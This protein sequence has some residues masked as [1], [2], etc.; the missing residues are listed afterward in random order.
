MNFN[1]IEQH[2]RLTLFSVSMIV[3]TF[4]TTFSLGELKPSAS[5]DYADLLGE[6]GIVAVTL[7]WIVVILISRPAG[8]LTNF[9][10][11]GL[12]FMHVS[13]LADFLDE[14]LYYSQEQVWITAYE[15]IPAPI[16][17]LLT[18]YGLFQWHKEQVS[19][20]QQLRKREQSLRHHQTI[21]FITGL[22]NPQFMTAQI[23]RIIERNNLKNCHLMMLDI[24]HFDQF[25]RKH[26]DPAADL[27]LRELSELFLMNIRHTDLLCRYAGDRFIVLMTN[28]NH[29]GVMALTKQLESAIA[30]YAIKPT[31]SV[32]P[33][34]LSFTFS[35][36]S[37]YEFECPQ[38]AFDLLNQRMEQQKQL[39]HQAA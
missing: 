23:D 16:G 32:M 14:F 21:D 28:I 6:G 10:V 8:Q 20:N 34:Y 27:V 24:N 31:D 2:F 18:T 13:V 19:I 4:L 39:R 1:L 5:Y 29:D 7:M 35:L 26:G 17:M 11:V 9:L 38:Q 3:L 25:V 37:G 30:S 22:S 12:V 15:S 33:D 36:C